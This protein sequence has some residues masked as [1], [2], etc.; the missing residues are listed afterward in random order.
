MSSFLQK[1]A[2]SA[3]QG[4]EDLNT[5]YL[6]QQHAERQRGMTLLQQLMRQRQ[7]DAMQQEEHQSSM[8]WRQA[9]IGNLRA[10]NLRASQPKPLSAEER[11]LQGSMLPD[12][13]GRFENLYRQRYSTADNPMRPTSFNM[14][15]IRQ[16]YLNGLADIEKR[17]KERH[18]EDNTYYYVPTPSDSN[19]V[20]RQ[21][22]NDYGVPP[23]QQGG[24]LS[25]L[26]GRAPQAP[27]VAG[28]P[29]SLQNRTNAY[30]NLGRMTKEDDQ[31]PA[32]DMNPN[33]VYESWGSSNIT[34][35]AQ[36][37]PQQ[38]LKAI[39]AA[40]AQGHVK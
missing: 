25:Q 33:E 16:T 23:E 35:W 11:Y 17:E 26:L 5:Q 2:Y 20:A 37:S 15:A 19:Y 4:L 3:G 29:M 40:R 30:G 28:R 27:P 12:E 36:L 10:D 39:A 6:P 32:T 8:N 38:K 22:V 1:L 7:A 9:Q 31:I 24:F 34:E 18:P 21:T 14:P 13:Q